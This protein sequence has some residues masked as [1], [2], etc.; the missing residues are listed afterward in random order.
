MK[1]LFFIFLVVGILASAAC[2]IWE[3]RKI[4]EFARTF[5][6]QSEIELKRTAL[7]V[8]YQ[9]ILRNMVREIDEL[10]HEKAER[11][12]KNFSELFKEETEV[13]P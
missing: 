6:A 1:R 3:Y 13:Q 10:K 11:D 2:H 12:R 9:Q 5:Q 8:I 7:M 4:R